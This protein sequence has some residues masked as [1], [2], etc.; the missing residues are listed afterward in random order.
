MAVSADE[1][2]LVRADRMAWFVA[3]ARTVVRRVLTFGGVVAAGWLLALVFGLLGAAPAVADTTAAT[4]AA[5]LDVLDS[6]VPGPAFQ[7][8][9]F[10]TGGG[11]L[12]V[13]RDAEA[14]AGRGVD[15]LTSQSKPGSPAP[16]SADHHSGANG[17]LPQGGGG[18]GLS[19]PGAGDVT[20]FVHD[21]RVT[22]RRAPV[23]RAVSPAVRTAADDPSFSPD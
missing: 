7:A 12:S 4:A 23:A 9:V 15:G 22:A 5:R 8:G 1:I 14:K 18:S 11:G 20:R 2:V 10:P 16:V 3:G 19:W 13:S 17:F 6:A 21:P